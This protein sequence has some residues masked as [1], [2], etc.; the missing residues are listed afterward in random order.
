MG[1]RPVA[2]RR[3]PGA[4]ASPAMRRAL[5]VLAAVLMVVLAMLVR[6]AIDDGDDGDDSG[7]G[8][9]D[10]AQDGDDPVDLLCAEE[11]A[12]VC[13][14]LEDAGVADTRV[15]PAGDTL[16]QLGDPEHDFRPDAW[17]TLDPFPQMVDERRELA[18][19]DPLFEQSEST[20]YSTPLA[21]A[22][23]DDRAAALEADC[24]D[25][26]WVCLGEAG[27]DP[28][29]DHH[30]EPDWGDVKLGYE[31]PDTSATGLL[32]LTQA[33]AD[34]VGVHF[35]G[36]DIDDRFLRDLEDAVPTRTGAGDPL[37]VM[38]QQGAAAFS[39]VGALGKDA[40]AATGTARGADLR[41]FYPAPMFRAEVVLA[42][43]AGD[44]AGSD[45]LADALADAGWEQGVDGAE[46]PP[47]GVLDALRT[48]WEGIQ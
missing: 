47:P 16:D 23:F 11:L 1:V 12:D 35:A 37:T 43:D 27:G 33:M 4:L 40:E 46:L 2:E 30:G 7:G 17:L 19:G 45:E 42:G 41:V 20:R 14:A 8:T 15:E 32:V 28:W 5:A 9:G 25:V 34:K 48:S 13:Q 3:R 21:I 24:T 44:L 18:L 22:A 39:A 6:A 26:G 31:A 38:L 29:E 10:H 36:Q